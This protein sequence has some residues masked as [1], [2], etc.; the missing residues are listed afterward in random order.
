MLIDLGNIYSV[1]PLDDLVSFLKLKNPLKG[2]KIIL[3]P[4][5]K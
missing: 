3:I 1:I 4:K 5:I 2:Q